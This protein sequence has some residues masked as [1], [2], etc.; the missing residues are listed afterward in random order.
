MKTYLFSSYRLGFRNW[1]A[2]DLPKLIQLNRCPKVM[3]YFPATLTAQSSTAF[4]QRLQQHYKEHGYTY[5][6]VDTLNN[7]QF[8]GFIGLA[9]QSFEASFTPA[10]DIGWRLLAENWGQGYATEGARACLT[11]AF[12]QLQLQSIIATCPTINNASERVM[13]KIGMQKQGHF[14]H[15]KLAQDSVL[16]DCVWYQIDVAAYEAKK[17][18]Y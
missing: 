13:Q 5:F 15:P 8:I 18:K 3:Q 14:V 4:M 2:Q 10:I 12:E 11:Y 9:N 17:T 7:Q 1:L 6:A 16:K